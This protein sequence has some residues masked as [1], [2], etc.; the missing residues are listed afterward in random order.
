M[1]LCR[2]KRNIIWITLLSGG[3]VCLSYIVA[4]L[5]FLFQQYMDATK[6]IAEA[7]KALDL[8]ANKTI[9][10]AKFVSTSP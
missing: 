10:I 6:A 1:F 2:N 8:A 3:I 9:I 5:L 7:N 4:V